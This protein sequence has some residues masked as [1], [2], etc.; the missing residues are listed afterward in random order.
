M[1]LHLPT[2]VVSLLAAFGL[3]ALG[4]ALAQPELRKRPELRLWAVGTW[5]LLAGVAALAS[6]PYLLGWLGIVLGNGLVLCGLWSF[7]CA[8]HRIVIDE[9]AP[10]WQ[11]YLVPAGWI[12]LLVMASLPEQV[13]AIGTAALFAAQL[14]PPLVLIALR[15]WRAETSLRTAAL[16]LGLAVVVLALHAVHPWDGF[17]L[18]FY[19]SLLGAGFALVLA[20]LERLA[21]NMKQLATHDVLTGCVNRV[22]FDA[23]LNHALE[24]GRRDREPVSLLLMD[25]D[26][27]KRINDRH[28]H[29][30]GDDVLRLF[31]QC[32]RERCRK[33]DVFGRLGGEEFALIL[34]ATDTNGALRLAEKVRGAV[35]RISQAVPGGERLSV[36]VSIGVATAQP[37]NDLSG[38]QAYAEAEEALAMAKQR[39]GNLAVHFVT[40]VRPAA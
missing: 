38:N 20:T 23:I 35:E 31:A 27:L 13:R 5:F 34:P 21:A 12:G 36:S 19:F 24:R 11:W 10:R 15:G 30:T 4:L 7:S 26:Q 37:R 8:F 2:L 39:G 18:L 29:S 40:A 32:V 25:L 3:L 22:Y 17:T 14:L 16:M 28:G 9:D 6:P 33:S 1:V